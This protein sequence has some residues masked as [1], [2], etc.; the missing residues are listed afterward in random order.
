MSLPLEPPLTS[1]AVQGCAHTDGDGHRHN[2]DA[3]GSGGHCLLQS[4]NKAMPTLRTRN[5]LSQQD[6]LPKKVKSSTCGTPNP[7]GEALHPT[8]QQH[9][10]EPS[11]IRRPTAAWEGAKGHSEH[12]ERLD[13]SLLCHKLQQEKQLGPGQEPLEEGLHQTKVLTCT[14]PVPAGPCPHPSPSLLPQQGHTHF[15]MSV[16]RLCRDTSF[17]AKWPRLRSW[18]KPSGS[19]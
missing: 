16:G 1:C 12:R 10:S 8:C 15:P 2:T 5:T 4:Q 13:Q 19:L 6:W 3:D 17:K 14:W 18:V 9:K 11:T 7:M